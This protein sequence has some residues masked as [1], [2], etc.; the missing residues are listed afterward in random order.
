M[1]KRLLFLQL[2]KWKSISL[3]SITA[4]MQNVAVVD[5]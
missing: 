5:E 1:E 4:Q 2:L 3:L